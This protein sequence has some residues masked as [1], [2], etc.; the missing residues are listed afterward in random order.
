MSQQP[1]DYPRQ[2]MAEVAN[3]QDPLKQ[4][5]VQV[6]VYDIFDGVPVADLPW[7]T[8]MLPLGTRPTDGGV[9]PVQVGD[10]VW[11]DF[12]NGGD[13]RRPR[14]LGGAHAI[15]GGKPN[16]P[17]EIW[18]G[19]G[20]HAHKRAE[21]EPVPE[22]PGYHEDVV[23][24]QH[25]VLI[26]LTKSGA[27]RA[28]QLASGSALEIAPDGTIVIH[29]ENNILMSAPNK[30]FMQVGPSSMNMDTSGITLKAP[31]IDLNP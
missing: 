11:V 1:K 21:G 30:I 10:L 12:P 15:P 22:A 4:M 14:I 25:G 31:R 17:P 2:Y 6:R 3:V 9:T 7:A 13:T 26:Q 20:Q 19:P 5:R 23:F 29:S 24:K 18:Q 16:M 8:Y 28:T 27:L